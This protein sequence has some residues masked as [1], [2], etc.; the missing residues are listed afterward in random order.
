VSIS[1]SNSNSATVVSDHH[2]MA[3]D[4]N[5]KYV[6]VSM[7]QLPAVI[8]NIKSPKSKGRYSIVDYDKI[9]IADL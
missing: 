5:V 7:M 3:R 8:D 9:A 1:I 4:L 2:E 6:V